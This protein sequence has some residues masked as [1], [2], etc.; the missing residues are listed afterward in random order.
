MP[1]VRAALRAEDCPRPVTTAWWAVGSVVILWNRII[2]VSVCHLITPSVYQSSILS[3]FYST[4]LF[5]VVFCL[6]DEA[7]KM[8]PFQTSYSVHPCSYKLNKLI[9]LPQR[10]YPCPSLSFLS[11]FWGRRGERGSGPAPDHRRYSRLYTD[12]K[13]TGF[14]FWGRPDQKLVRIDS[15]QVKILRDVS[16][17]WWIRTWRCTK[18][19]CLVLIILPAL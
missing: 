18:C 12:K 16:V 11:V 19:T 10:S 5:F 15:N 9:N 7:Q 3:I 13:N 8:A 6:F 1:T 17:T 4:P 14:E 2:S